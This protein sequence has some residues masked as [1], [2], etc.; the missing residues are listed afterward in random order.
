[1]SV[2]DDLVEANRR[3][4]DSTGALSEPPPMPPSRAV[5]IVTCMDARI[6]P[7]QIFGLR[8]GDA[9]VIRNAGGSAREALRSVVI[10]ERLLGTQAVAVIKHTDCGM[11][12]FKNEDLY[13]KV[14]EDLGADASDIDF[15]P[16]PELESAVREDVELLKNSPLVPDDI[17]VRG[18][19]YDVQT[20]RL[21]EVN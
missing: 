5:A 18:F 17:E 20:R 14:Q 11:L 16:F 10:S 6:V 9:H 19:V 2:I 8:E 12:T 7:A 21:S 1:M 15:L 4:A 3:F 13:A